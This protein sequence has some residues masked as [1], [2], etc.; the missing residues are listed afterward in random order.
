M[1][2]TLGCLLLVL[3][4]NSLLWAEAMFIG[5]LK[6]LLISDH[7]KCIMHIS[8]QY[9]NKVGC[10]AAFAVFGFWYGCNM[11]RLVQTR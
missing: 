5:W 3:V 4:F 1:Y 2:H 8:S 7:G 11:Q 6:C 9:P 10:F